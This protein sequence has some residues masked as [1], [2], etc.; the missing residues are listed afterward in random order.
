MNLK[1][2]PEKRIILYK[3]LKNILIALSFAWVAILIIDS[4]LVGFL[5]SQVSFFKLTL[6][7]AILLSLIYLITKD[8]ELKKPGKENKNNFLIISLSIIIFLVLILANLDFGAFSIA[9]IVLTSLLIMFY[10]YKEL[11]KHET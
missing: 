8:F 7:T 10:F 6:I 3:L 2:S 1:I 4:I 5:S 9:T 11:V